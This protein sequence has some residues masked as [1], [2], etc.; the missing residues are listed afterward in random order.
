MKDGNSSVLYKYKSC[1]AFDEKIPLSRL[2][3][4]IRQYLVTDMVEDTYVNNAIKNKTF[5]EKK[6]KVWL[7]KTREPNP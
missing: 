5:I 3:E 2:V 6:G 1:K 4:L 7:I